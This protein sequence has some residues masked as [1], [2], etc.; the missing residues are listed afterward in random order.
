MG[1]VRQKPGNGADPPA[2]CAGRE[3]GETSISGAAA[4]RRDRRQPFCAAP[5]P[6]SDVTGDV[7]TH[8]ANPVNGV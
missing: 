6:E 4:R 2:G 7:Q 1:P 3:W 5:L 8:L